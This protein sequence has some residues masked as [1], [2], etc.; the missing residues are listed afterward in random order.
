MQKPDYRIERQQVEDG[1]AEK[2]SKTTY[3]EAKDSVN[4]FLCSCSMRKKNGKSHVPHPPHHPA[5]LG[6][7]TV[8]MQRPS[9][10]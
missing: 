5:M 8:P 4:G 9:L 1:R 3:L 2:P 6:V 10:P 7:F